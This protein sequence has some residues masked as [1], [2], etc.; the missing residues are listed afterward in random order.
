[1]S[2]VVIGVS[3]VSGDR[4]ALSHRV[5][6]VIRALMAVNDQRW[7]KFDTKEEAEAQIKLLGP[8]YLTYHVEEYHV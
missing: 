8:G 3:P 2:Y 6:S 7:A 5:T 1:M 4:Y